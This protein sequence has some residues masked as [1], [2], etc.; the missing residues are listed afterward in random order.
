MHILVQTEGPPEVI[1]GGVI[2]D[3]GSEYE[4]ED[5]EVQDG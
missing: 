5:M 2:K 3:S 4:I 1:E